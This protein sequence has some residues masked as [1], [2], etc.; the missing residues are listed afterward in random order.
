MKQKT[1]IAAIQIFIFLIITVLV[2]STEVS[3]IETRFGF[4]QLMQEINHVGS[5]IVAV[6]RTLVSIITAVLILS[7][8]VTLW[9]ARDG[10]A[11][12]VVKVR[13]IFIFVGLLIVFMAEPITNFIFYLLGW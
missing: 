13:V 11:L 6:V 5:V 8:G 1:I 12:E 4:N 9:Q 2:F 10:I 7:I 3:A